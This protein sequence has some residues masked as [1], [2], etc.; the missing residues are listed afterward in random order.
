MNIVLDTSVLLVSVSN[1]SPFYWIFD[2]FVNEQFVLYA[3]T[4]ILLEYEEVIARH[5]G[6]EVALDV[7]QTIE[8]APNFEKVNLYFKWD[9]IKA[10]PDDNKFVDCAIA[11]NAAYLVSEDGH[12]KILKQIDFPKVEVL[13]VNEFKKLLNPTS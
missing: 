1:R 13:G 4:D 8:N 5:M 6:K 3:T 7:M 10:D 2:Y 12:F 11:A 9:L